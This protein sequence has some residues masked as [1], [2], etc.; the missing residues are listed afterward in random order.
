MIRSTMAASIIAW[1]LLFSVQLQAAE[2]TKTVKEHCHEVAGEQEL[3]GTKYNNFMKMCTASSS[4][5]KIR[6]S[7]DDEES[8]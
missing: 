5:V 1:A 6:K 3:K 7:N 8:H 2:K 4:S